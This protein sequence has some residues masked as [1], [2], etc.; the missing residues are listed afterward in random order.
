ML[1]QQKERVD[2]LF[3]QCR[4]CEAGY[5]PVVQSFM[6]VWSLFKTGMFVFVSLLQQENFPIKLFT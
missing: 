2:S 1:T 3:Y 4:G 5:A 6:A